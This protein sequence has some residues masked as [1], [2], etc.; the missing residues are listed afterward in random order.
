[1][2]WARLTLAAQPGSPLAELTRSGR[3][4]IEGTALGRGLLLRIAGPDAHAPRLRAALE[5]AGARLDGEDAR[6]GSFLAQ[7]DLPERRLLDAVERAGGI[8]VPPLRWES[9][10]V[11]V[12][13]LQTRPGLVARV[14]RSFPVKVA[15]KRPV[16]EH[17]G[18]R[19]VLRDS[20]LLPSLTKKQAQALVAALDAGYYDLPRRVTTLDVARRLGV[21]R[22]TFEEH[23]RRAEGQLVGALAPLARLK[24]AEEGAARA[25]AA[26]LYARYSEALGLYVQMSVR[27]EQVTGVQL[28]EHPAPGAGREHPYLARILEHLASGSEDL[29]DIPLDLDVTPFERRV[30]DALRKV[31]AG[32][33]LTYGELARR[34]GAPRGARAVGN[35][36]ARNPA[37]L[38]VPCHRAVRGDGDLGGYAGAGGPR[39]KERLLAL[40]GA[41]AGPRA[42]RPRRG[43][44]APRTSQATGS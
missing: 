3:L 33:V 44:R 7:G 39:T 14:Q 19:E 34:L 40:E 22:S 17:A 12:E 43:S 28:A 4:R 6:G 25:E 35:A 24:L 5:G 27:A 29:S 1:M 30:L 13:V 8:V 32:E 20:L 16:A 21:A 38:L 41:L 2:T 26:Q 31:P 36:C 9:G 18:A 23:L 10:L 15:R 11:S 37:L 42:P